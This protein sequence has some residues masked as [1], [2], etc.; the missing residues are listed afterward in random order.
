[1]PVARIARHWADADEENCTFDACHIKPNGGSC[2]E[3]Q[4]FRVISCSRSDGRT[5]RRCRRLRYSPNSVPFME[6]ASLVVGRKKNIKVPAPNI[7]VQAK[8]KHTGPAVHPAV[9]TLSLRLH[10]I[11]FVPGN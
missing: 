9:V 2:E 10:C 8:K 6:D 7:A 5:A 11:P 3:V 1:M 4:K